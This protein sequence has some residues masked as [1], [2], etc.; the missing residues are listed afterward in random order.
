MIEICC[1]CRVVVNPNTQKRVLIDAAR[2]MHDFC[3]AQH[4]YELSVRAN[5][6]RKP[7]CIKT[8]ASGAGKRFTIR[9]LY[10]RVGRAST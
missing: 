7:P 10:K 8:D 4:L 9:R 1:K 5:G 3:Y 6:G 2:V